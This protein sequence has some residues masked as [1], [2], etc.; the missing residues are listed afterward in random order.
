MAILPEL[1]FLAF[2]LDFFALYL[3]L[4]FGINYIVHGRK[5]DSEIVRRYSFGLGLFF[6]S[7]ALSSLLY[8]VDLSSRTLG[9]GRLFPAEAEYEAMGYI[10]DSF[11]PQF[12][13][14]V[15]LAFMLLAMSFL[16]NPIEK[17]M[18]TKTKGIFSKLCL[19]LF[20]V[21]F[22]VRILEIVTLPVTG[23]ILYYIYTGIYFLCWAVMVCV[24]L[25][26]WGLY[27]KMAISGTG[28]VRKRAVAIILGIF[29]W[30]GAIFMKSAF[31]KDLDNYTFWLIAVL[32]IVMITFFVYGF[33][34]NL[35]LNTG[36]DN[37]HLYQ[38]WLFKVV[39]FGVI[40][41]V[42]IYFSVL[43]WERDAIITYTLSNNPI[44]AE[45]G[46]FMDRSAFEGDGFG[47]QDLTYIVFVIA[48]LLY[49]ASYIPALEPKLAPIRKYAGFVIVV[50]LAVTVGGSRV[51]KFVFGRAR[52]GDV[53]RG[54]Y[55]F[56]HMLTFG[57][58]PL[59]EAFSR[60]SFPSGHTFTAMG[61]VVLAFIAIRSHKT[62]LIS[63]IFALT[64]GYGVIMGFGRVVE[65]AHYPGDTLWAIIFSL[66]LTMWI[67]FSI[68][69]IPEQERGE[70]T[71][72]KKF[73]EIR[74]GVNLV[75][76]E[77]ALGAAIVGLRYTIEAFEWYW[78][79]AIVAGLAI[80]W[81]FI[82]RLNVVRAA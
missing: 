59:D 22:I 15:I 78:P 43:F 60:G 73:A 19:I 65:G 24:I 69:K 58:Y 35:E 37:S 25:M 64:I 16:I 49:F 8:M 53:F 17:Y 40:G 23:S 81:V 3:I 54:E 50:A 80:M 56:T 20:P 44:Y 63:S 74:I 76:I 66:L 48:V 33:G 7:V 75:F 57:S 28:D 68:L 10:F 67:Y 55:A 4:A 18:I 27:I 42:A 29:I 45:F 13:F 39:V 52:P 6:I 72:T 12:Y 34:E 41:L 38:Y 11:H 32:Q 61:L 5:K 1:K 36:S 9:H 70:Y 2:A 71:L 62:W 79:V 30:L 14:I 46:H 77:F 47:G 51:G 21:P 26:L 31:Y 82:W